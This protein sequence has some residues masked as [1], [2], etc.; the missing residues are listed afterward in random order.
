M[1]SRL[2]FLKYEGCGNDF[3][4]VDEL[5]ADRTRDELR[6]TLAV[7]LC[8]RHVGI[9]ADGL[10]FIESA[11]ATDGSMRLFEPAGNEADMCGNGLR[12]VACYL[13]EM[14]G[15]DDLD[16]LTRDGVKR[17]RRKGDQFIVDMGVV[18]THR[19]HISQYMTDAGDARD[20]M[21][22]TVI[23]ARGEDMR[24]SVLNSGEPHI[25]VTTDDLS[26][27]DV[28]G[29]GT[30][31]NADRDRFP[32]GININF[33]QVDDPGAIRIRT[34]ERGVYDETLACG[35]G[36]TACAVA[37]LLKA[38][39]SEGVVQVRTTGGMLTI[40]LKADGHALMSGPAKRV[41]R[42]VVDI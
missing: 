12:C 27:V 36:A 5:G 38:E 39:R 21:L 8:K 37:Y 28:V 15:K 7:R 3:I 29:V 17:V 41:F 13:S 18:R 22:D 34:Y 42:G 32:S 10:I 33:V 35:T 25:V 24:A 1:A 9:G 31:L 16:I 26:A 30:E 23:T 6:S 40:E 19:E 14:T 4:I 20:S 2:E 11:D